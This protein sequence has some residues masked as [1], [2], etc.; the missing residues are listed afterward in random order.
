MF[1]HSFYGGNIMPSL[2]FIFTYGNDFQF[3]KICESDDVTW[4]HKI[5]QV[6]I[7]LYQET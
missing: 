7:A 6:L 5:M 4:H 3:F 1:D 2:Y